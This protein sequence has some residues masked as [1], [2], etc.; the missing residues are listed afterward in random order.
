MV[1]QDFRQ[2]FTMRIYKADKRTKSGE[3]IVSTTVWA[4]RTAS[5]M[6]RECA[7]L[8][9]LLYPA[10]QGYRF[11]YDPTFKTVKSLM[12]GKDVVIAADTPFCCDPSTETFWSS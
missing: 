3:K 1:K 4:G 11:E 9:A 5:I 8:A 10:K 6:E 2:D 12:T 7:A